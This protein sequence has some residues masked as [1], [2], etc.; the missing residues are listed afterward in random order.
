M[1][2]NFS[3]GGA[4]RCFTPLVTGLYK[5]IGNSRP[6]SLLVAS[7]HCQTHLWLSSSLPHTRA[8]HGPP[9]P[10]RPALCPKPPRPRPDAVPTTP[11]PRPWPFVQAGTA[12][13]GG[14]IQFTRTSAWTNGDIAR[15]AMLLNKLKPKLLVSNRSAIRGTTGQLYPQ[16]FQKHV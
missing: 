5:T 15:R 4:G 3:R 9:P 6:T 8:R 11:A 12:L 13:C 1:G 7:W 10:S 16:N 2:E 14:R